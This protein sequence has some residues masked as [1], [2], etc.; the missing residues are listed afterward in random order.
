MVE[1]LA[2]V[3][4][5]PVVASNQAFAWASLRAAGVRDALPDRGMLFGRV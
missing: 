4:C 3:L 1:A 2:R 5:K